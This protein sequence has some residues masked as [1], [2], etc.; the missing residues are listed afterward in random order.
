MLAAHAVGDDRLA[1]LRTR[2]G[3]CATARRSGIDGRTEGGDG[4]EAAEGIDL[5]SENSML[6]LACIEP[7]LK[8]GR[9]VQTVG[10]VFPQR[11]DCLCRLAYTGRNTGCTLDHPKD[12][13]HDL[14]TGR[15]ETATRMI[16]E[17]RD[18]GIN[19]LDAVSS[20]P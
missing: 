17:V 16:Q 8:I 9:L 11:P 4:L 6:N 20:Q 12:S 5:C 19:S 13:P 10:G 3:A 2:Y 18:R 14:G 7:G 1:D 15:R